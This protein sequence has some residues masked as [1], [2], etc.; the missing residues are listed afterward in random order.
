MV[1]VSLNWNYIVWVE[2]WWWTSRLWVCWAVP[3]KDASVQICEVTL[4][5]LVLRTEKFVL[6]ELNWEKAALAGQFGLKFRFFCIR[7]TY[8]W[9]Y[10]RYLPGVM[11][12]FK[13]F[14]WLHGVV[15]AF[16]FL[17]S[18]SKYSSQ[19]NNYGTVTKEQVWSEMSSHFLYFVDSCL[20]LM[21]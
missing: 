7:L 15:V 12:F 4:V 16:I 21:E 13:L 19:A 11:Y 9:W 10:L 5:C 14:L 2:S 17:K 1:E 3:S 18:P 6:R 20:I 8:W